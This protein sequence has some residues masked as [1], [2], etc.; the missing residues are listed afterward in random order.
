MGKLFDRATKQVELYHAWR[1]IRENGIASDAEETRIAVEIFEKQLN[2]NIHRIQRRL[3]SGEFEF[4]PQTGILKKKSSGGYRGIVLASIHNRVVERAWLDAL[5]AGSSLVRDV[6][7]YPTSVGGVPDR[8]VPHGLKLIRDAIDSGRRYFVRSDIS[9]FFDSIARNSVIERI[10]R[11]INDDKFVSV[12]RAA[13]TVTLANEV[14]L[15]E[16]R[17]VFPSSDLGV[18]QGSPLSPLFGNILLYDFDKKFN[19][20]GVICVRFI[21][22]FLILASDQR[23]ANKAFQSAK[24]F[25][26]GLALS[27]HDPF[28]GVVNAE[29]AQSGHVDSGFIFL[30]YDIRPGLFQP[31]NKARQK[32]E[33]AIDARIYAGKKAISE[34]KSVPDGAENT[35]RYAQTIVSIDRIVRGWGN[36]FAYGNAQSTINQL[37]ERIDAKLN[38][39]RNWYSDQIRGQDLKVRRRT[40][41]VCL[42]GDIRPKNLDDIPF[43]LEPGGR[44]V[45]SK[46]TLTISTD[47]SVVTSGR[48]KGKDRGKGGWAFVIHET[49]EEVSGQCIDATNN[50]ME[51][52]AVIEEVKRTPSE[53]SLR[54]RTDSQY[55]AGIINQGNLV[56][57]NSDLWKEYHAVASGRRIK[58]DWIK[59]HSGDT[60][61]DQADKLANEQARSVHKEMAAGDKVM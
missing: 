24:E 18:A 47:G 44:F 40:G 19:D 58:V 25:L 23:S 31:S 36:S 34:L 8:S 5:Q 12:L 3:K 55:V 60:Y 37:D 9:G 13:T 51:L 21:D 20:R 27:C 14:A 56:K 39:F 35:S 30:G 11:D 59:G 4:E 52:T 49:G 54:I 45:Q 15:G 2:R 26:T 46:K 29:K 16:D 1:K 7:T 17:K 10:S 43:K 6:I 48:R 53:N 38:N 41:G 57:S 22:D 42:L 33:K 32:L 28:A 61:N 50:Q